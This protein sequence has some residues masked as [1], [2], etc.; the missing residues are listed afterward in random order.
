MLKLSLRLKTVFDMVPTGSVIADVGSD[1]GKLIISLFEQGIISH[2]YAIENKKGPFER[3][4]KA[5]EESGF[6]QFITPMFSDGI[7]ELPSDVGT[8]ILAGMGGNLVIS[9]L[10]DG[11]EKLKNVDTIIVDAH[12]CIPKIRKDICDMGY[13]IADEKII[14]EDGIFYEIIKFVKAEKAFYGD[15]DFEFGPIL[16]NEKSATFREKYQS[17]IKEIDNLI[18]TSKI[19]TSRLSILIKEK[20]RIKGVL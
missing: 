3:L 8:I 14:K 6:K 15:N 18:S 4:T 5:I 13:A 20:D 2:G 10:K 12:S 19:P 17:R 11:Q 9:I 1:H 7:K 16:R